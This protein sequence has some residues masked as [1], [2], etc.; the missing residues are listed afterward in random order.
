[1]GNRQ[2]SA[3][4]ASASRAAASRP[5]WSTL[6]AFLL[7]AFLAGG[8][9]VAVRFSNSGLPPFWGATL[10]FSAAALIFWSIVLVRHTPVPKGRALLGAVLYG[11][12]SIGLAYAGLYWGL[13]R[14]PAGLAGAVIALAP[15]MT[16]FFAAGHG[17][18]ILHWRGLVGALVA[19][20]GVLLGAVGGF[21]GAMH[22]PSVLALV[23]GVACTAESGVVYK[24]FPNSDPMVYNAVSLTTGVP[25]LAA[26]SRLMGERWALPATARTWAAYA[27][28]VVI[29]SVVVFYLF[30]YVLSHWTASAASY[31]GLLIPVSAVVL[32]ALLA[33]EAITPSFL[34]GAAM[35]IAGV[36]LGALH[37]QPEARPKIDVACT[38]RHSEVPC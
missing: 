13:V 9:V 16:L 15:L 4:T 7:A 18:E 20:A 6:A 5:D 23:A 30:L 33:G 32:G 8:N 2:S 38:E 22:V 10:R 34:L 11:L 28:L 31:L 19:T 1:M 25:L 29:G 17:L 27:Y 36:W 3:D 35:V 24:L 14:A 26:L 21:G 12:L 37:Q